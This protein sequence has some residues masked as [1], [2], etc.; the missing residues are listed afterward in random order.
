MSA[1]IT[2]ARWTKPL[3]WLRHAGGRGV[4][5]LKVK[6]LRPYRKVYSLD[7]IKPAQRRN[8]NGLLEETNMAFKF[9]TNWPKGVL[10]AL[11]ATGLLGGI[12]AESAEIKI[13]QNIPQGPLASLTYDGAGGPAVGTDIDFNLIIGVDTPFNAGVTLT[14]VGCQLDFT[15]G[16]NTGEGPTIWTFA[17]GGSFVLTGTVPAVFG[18]PGI[19]VPTALLSG[20]F[21]GDPPN[22]AVGTG[23][24][25][26]AFNGFGI[27]IKEPKL[28]T[29][30][31]G[32][33]P[34]PGDPPVIFNY[35]N[36]EITGTG[37]VGLD[38]SFSVAVKDADI[39]NSIPEPGSALLL[40]LG[41]GSLAAY[42]R[43]RS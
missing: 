41:L 14:C 28:V 16:A 30:F 27:D 34:G 40:L 4:I 18:F 7:G 6:A 39:S 20:S 13:D 33:T 19:F 17:S 36:T 12:T 22:L 9:G 25:I 43:R 42:R 21:T 3:V 32:I 23:S 37:T 1:G 2:L 11:V 31:Y 24:A 35:S 15:T 26:F 38:G 10:A 5:P 8:V 29:Y